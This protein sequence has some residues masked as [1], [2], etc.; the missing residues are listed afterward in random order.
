M[1]DA[2][3]ETVLGETNALLERGIAE[4]KKIMYICRTYYNGRNRA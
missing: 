4:V 3:F 2:V 1:T